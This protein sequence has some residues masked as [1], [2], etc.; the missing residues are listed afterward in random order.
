MNRQVF[1]FFLYNKLHNYNYYSYTI[2]YII[3]CTIISSYVSVNSI[4]DD[5]KLQDLSLRTTPLSRWDI[6]PPGVPYFETG[7]GPLN[8]TVQLGSR[9]TLH[10]K[11]N[12]LADKIAVS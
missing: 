12:Q 8:L 4:G 1:F 11:V 3:I 5:R 2:T 7:P 9:I 10:C 6:P